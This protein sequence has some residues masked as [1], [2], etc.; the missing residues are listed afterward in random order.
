[1]LAAG[2]VDADDG[3]VG[4]TAGA[5]RPRP[6]SATGSRASASD[7][8]VGEPGRR[9]RSRLALDRARRRRCGRRRR[10][11]AAASDSEPDLPAPPITATRPGVD[12]RVATYWRTT[13]AVSAGAPQTSITASA[14]SAGR[15]SGSTAAIER[16]KRIACPSAGTCSERPSQPARPSVIAAASGSARPASRP[17]RRPPGRAA[18]RGPTSSTVPTSMPPEPVTGFCILPRVAMMSS[19]SART[20]SPSPPCL[21]RQLPE[22]RGV[23]V[24]PLDRDPHLVRPELAAGSSR[25]AAWGS[26]PAGSRTR[27][28]PTGRRTSGLTGDSAG[29]SCRKSLRQYVDRRRFSAY[30][31]STSSYMTDGYQPQDAMSSTSSGLSAEQPYAYRRPSSSSP[32]GPGCPGWRDVT[33]E[34]VGSRRSGSGRT[35]SRTSS[36]CGTLMGDLLDDRFYADLERDQAERATMSMLVPPQMMNTMVP[37]TAPRRP[38]YRGVLRRPGAPLHAAGLLRPAYRLAVPPVRHPRL[39][40]RARHVGGRG[41]DPPLPDQGARRAAADLPAV[42]R[43]LHPDGPR[44][45]LD[46][47]DPQAEVRPQAGRPATTR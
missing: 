15:S 4:R 8:L 47:G 7:D 2:H 21:V 44:R 23:E 38:A 27:C 26:T 34:R 16:P 17:G 22:R 36:S 11:R 20:A 46:P 25:S 24:E 42:L 6:R 5:P 14:S 29:L 43:P 18:T 41:P 37:A 33:A 28:R 13:R 45:Q 10:R 31:G 19:T 40:A 9:S 39:A 12:P 35:A 3:D 30:R 32:T 1:M